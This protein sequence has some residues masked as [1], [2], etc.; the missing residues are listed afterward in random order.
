MALRHDFFFCIIDA[1]RVEQEPPIVLFSRGEIYD[2]QFF[3]FIHISQRPFLFFFI[4]SIRPFQRE[5]LCC[6]SFPVFFVLP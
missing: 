3:I 5:Y 1:I 6:F 2:V 4:D